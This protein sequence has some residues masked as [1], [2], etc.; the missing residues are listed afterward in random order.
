MIR[1]FRVAEGRVVVLPR[2]VQAGPGNAHAVF[3]A[4]ETFSLGEERCQRY[5]RRRVDAGDIAEVPPAS[6]PS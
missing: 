1:T 6:T 3:H 4:G 5:I 2:D